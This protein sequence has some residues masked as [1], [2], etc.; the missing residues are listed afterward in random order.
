MWWD[1]Y[2][3]DQHG[4]HMAEIRDNLF[5]ALADEQRRWIL[6]S[7]LERGGSINIDS[8]PDGLERESLIV[9]RRHV[10]LPKLDK[11]GFIEWRRNE[12]VVEPGPRF[13][14]VEPT[15]RLMAENRDALPLTS[16]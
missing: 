6:F 4:T 16:A 12:R 1:E 7:L 10:H 3:T 13:E 11:Y 2:D 9:E 14:A 15:L 8:P 5:D